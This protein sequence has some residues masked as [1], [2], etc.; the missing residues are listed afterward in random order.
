M[1]LPQLLIPLCVVALHQGA[2][3]RIITP[4]EAAARCAA[5]QVRY[6]NSSSQGAV[7]ARPIAPLRHLHSI[8]MQD[9]VT[10]M[11]HL[12]TDGEH[13]ILAGADTRQR[14]VLG[15]LDAGENAE[16][17]AT[18]IAEMA[19]DPCDVAEQHPYHQMLTLYRREAE[20]LASMPESE[21]GDMEECESGWRAPEWYDSWMPVSPMLTT[22]WSQTYPYNMYAPLDMPTGCVATAMAQVIYHHRYAEG[23]GTNRYHCSSIGKELSYDYEGKHFD[24]D[25]M[26]PTYNHGFSD[27]QLVAVADLM[28]A[29]GVSVNMAY[30]PGN[31]VV[32][33]SAASQGLNRHFGYDPRGTVAYT[34]EGSAAREWETMVYE[35]IS[36]G[37]PVIYGGIT[38]EGAG[39]AFV[40]DGYSSEGL[41]H[42]NWGWGKYDG[43]F[44]LSSLNPAAVYPTGLTEGQQAVTVKVPWVGNVIDRTRYTAGIISATPHSMSLLW[45]MSGNSD[46]L[47]GEFGVVAT[48]GSSGEECFIA[49]T[50]MIEYNIDDIGVREDVRAFTFDLYTAL[51]RDGE[52]RLTPAVRDADGKV[53]K[54]YPM[55]NYP[56]TAVASIAAGK[57]E[58]TLSPVLA[59]DLQIE[60]FAPTDTLYENEEA[61]FRFTLTNNADTDIFNNIG[62]C[63]APAEEMATALPRTSVYVML[64]SGDSATYTTPTFA[65]ADKKA[66][67]LPRGEYAVW[68]VNIDADNARLPGCTIKVR[69]YGRDEDP[70]SVEMY[71]ISTIPTLIHTLQGVEVKQPLPPGLYIS[72][73]KV[74]ALP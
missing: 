19:S 30:A 21:G 33:V 8:S 66:G 51:T 63:I 4:N 41:F 3:A 12:L 5:L 46:N 70:S 40:V 50:S 29:C 16:D 34:R 67:I 60:G 32:S 35:E 68:L 61:A 24:F 62:V 53:A 65:L 25:N 48:H 27:A 42:I 71:P 52:W 6:A 10:P 1:K 54:A 57:V 47:E 37:R 17:I 15:V 14:R 20:M 49:G 2:Q 22:Q 43:Y 38:N 56:A 9:G 18:L 13:L 59:A 69:I 58:V 44:A 11:C 23:R 7:G 39:H 36:A 74:V 72:N 55:R 26:L 73:G 28:Y 45:R 64:K 31:S